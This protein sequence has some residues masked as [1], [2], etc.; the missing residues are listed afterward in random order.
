MDEA[1]QD[2]R[3]RTAAMVED[4]QVKVVSVSGG[5]PY[6]GIPENGCSQGKHFVTGELT[7]PF[8]GLTAGTPVVLRI[9]ET[10]S[11]RAGTTLAYSGLRRAGKGKDGTFV[12][13]GRGT[14]LPVRR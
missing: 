8:D 6:F 11:S 2:P 5:Y 10:G 14:A 9:D 7:A 13:C 3:F 1:K 12:Y 4:A